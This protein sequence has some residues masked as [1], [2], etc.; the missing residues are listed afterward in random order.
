M[1]RKI[2]PINPE[3]KF[4]NK[5]TEYNGIVYHSL[6]E[7][8]Y[9]AEL[10]L[11]KRSGEVKEWFRQVRVPLRI[12]GKLICTYV[13]DFMYRDKNDREF[14]VE[15][16]GHETPVWKLKWALFDALYPQFRKQLVK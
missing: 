6:K 4:H 10:D 11:L 8:R 3:S 9:A 5:Q 14:Y 1:Y 16:K 7:A 15:V 2:R 13:V 12:N